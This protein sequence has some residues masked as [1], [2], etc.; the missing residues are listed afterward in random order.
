MG[1]WLGRM[2]SAGCW[3]FLVVGIS[4][5]SAASP[6]E[7]QLRAWIRDLNADSFAAREGAAEKLKIAGPLAVSL[8][9]DCVASGSAEASWRASAVLVAIRSASPSTI[10]PDQA[11]DSAQCNDV[12]HATTD[13]SNSPPAPEAPPEA[14]ISQALA[15]PPAPLPLEAVTEQVLIADAYVSPQLT[16]EKGTGEKAFAG[17]PIPPQTWEQPITP[18]VIERDPALAVHSAQHADVTFVRY[19]PV[20]AGTNVNRENQPRWMNFLNRT[21]TMFGLSVR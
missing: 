6:S 21:R 18:A 7:E 5:A 17:A 20:R 13:N 14:D 8:L 4:F 9:S 3:L 2:P 12:G 19:P 16:G 15:P 1:T 10:L 11:I